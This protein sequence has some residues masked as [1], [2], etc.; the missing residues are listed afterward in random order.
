M[1]DEINRRTLLST[2]AAVAGTAA[3]A[4]LL[5]A[6]GGG[7]QSTGGTNT[8]K[9]L[10]AALPAYVP[11][12]A[13]KPDIPSVAGGTDIATDP[14]FL[15]YPAQRPRTVDG[16]PGKGGSYTAV[17]PLWGTVPSPD[18][19]FNRAMNKALVHAAQRGRTVPHAP[20]SPPARGYECVPNT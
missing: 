3:M 2:A 10:K 17:T 20:P 14:G 4:P 19:S 12:S 13:V 1:T 8:K 5:S 18:N 7:G 9:G 6:C 16:V 11:S 15:T